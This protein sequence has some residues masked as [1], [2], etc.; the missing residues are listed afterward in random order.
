VAGAVTSIV[1][2]GFSGSGTDYCFNFNAPFTAANQ[3]V[4][5]QQGFVSPLNL[6][7]GGIACEMWIDASC[8]N[9]TPYGQIFPTD[10]TGTVS[11]S[12]SKNLIP[13]AWA[14]VNLTAANFGAVN[15]GAVTQIVIQG[16]VNSNGSTYGT[17]NV[18][19]DDIVAY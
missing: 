13:G 3:S 16:S 7:G 17:G 18:K 4:A 5:I 6:T 2:P 12:F 8:T 14:S 1:A 19:I 9:G 11:Y 10:N 15:A